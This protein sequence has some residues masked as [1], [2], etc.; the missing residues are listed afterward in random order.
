MTCPFYGMSAFSYLHHDRGLLISTNG[1][2]CAL[3]VDHAAP[4]QMEAMGLA[5]DAETCPLIR[6]VRLTAKIIEEH[7]PPASDQQ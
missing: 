6:E 2:Q 7:L 4:C 3:L 1:N 5:P